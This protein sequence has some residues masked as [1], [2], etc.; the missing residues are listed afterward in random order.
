MTVSDALAK[1]KSTRAF[2]DKEETILSKETKIIVQNYQEKYLSR[3]FDIIS[4][5]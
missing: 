4:D 1:R 5:Q 2:L 3:S